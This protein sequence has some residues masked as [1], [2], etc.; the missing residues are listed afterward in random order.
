MPEITRAHKGVVMTVPYGHTGKTQCSTSILCKTLLTFFF[1]FLNLLILWLLS[2]MCHGYKSM[3]NWIMKLSTCGFV[4][5]CSDHMH[6]VPE[7]KYIKCGKICISSNTCFKQSRI[8]QQS[9]NL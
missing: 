6:K 5:F 9:K 2:F 8:T 1:F 3:I 7:I 4:I